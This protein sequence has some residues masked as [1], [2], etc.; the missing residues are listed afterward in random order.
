MR[1][2]GHDRQLPI[3]VPERSTQHVKITHCLTCDNGYRVVERGLSVLSGKLYRAKR[4][5]AEALHS[6]YF[7]S[8]YRAVQR[9]SW[10][11]HCEHCHEAGEGL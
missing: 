2:I 6:H 11:E 9:L 7:I 10:E 1:K 4:G 3:V 8:S 5:E